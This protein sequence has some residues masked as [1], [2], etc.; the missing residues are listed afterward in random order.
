MT[1][2]EP[3]IPAAPASCPTLATGMVSV[4]GHQ[5]QLWVGTKQANT[6][7]RI[8]FYWHGTGSNSAEAQ[9]EMGTQI[10]EIVAGGGM[11]ASF[12]DSTMQGDTVNNDV[13]YTGD[14]PMADTLLACAVKQ[15]NID[16]HQIYTAG[17]SAGGLM[18]G[19]MAFL[20]SSYIA[21]AMP[22]SGG[23]I[24]NFTLQNSHV[25]AVITTHGPYSSDMV[26][27]YFETTSID[28][29]NLIAAAGG[30]AVDCND[31][32]GHCGAPQTV[33][34]AQWTFCKAHPFGVTPEP[35]A[36]G[37]PSTFPSYCSIIKPE[38]DAGNPYA[39]RS[40]SDCGAGKVCC[41]TT[42]GLYGSITEGETSACL[43]TGPQNGADGECPAGK[44][45]LCGSASE[46]TGGLKC[47]LV[48]GGYC[49]SD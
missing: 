8:L 11:V 26:Q 31:G 43:T 15:L 14:L 20:R 27:V 44:Y 46:C 6:K 18:A 37:L 40:T 25:P 45:Q 36:S 2:T 16:T 23:V 32:A 42:G 5:V 28:E 29:D 17:C 38:V 3:Q 10:T 47:N 39:C 21:A 24:G 12:T 48:A 33:I 4:L 49:T 34:A 35:Y 22:N 1:D 19:S 9:S 30:F 13:W 41:L 7:G